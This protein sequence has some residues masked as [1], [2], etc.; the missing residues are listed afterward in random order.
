MENENIRTYVL[1]CYGTED[2]T[3]PAD[4]LNKQLVAPPWGTAAAVCCLSVLRLVV[5]V[6]APLLVPLLQMFYRVLTDNMAKNKLTDAEIRK[7]WE[8]IDP[9]NILK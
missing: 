2:C 3:V 1:D 6:C 8:Q 9:D 4:R 5:C 7:I